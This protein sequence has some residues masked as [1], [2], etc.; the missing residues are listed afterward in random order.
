[1]EK[2]PAIPA[3]GRS[4][5]VTFKGFRLCTM[6]V[7]DHDH[8]YWKGKPRRSQVKNTLFIYEAGIGYIN[9]DSG[10]INHHSLN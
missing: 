10:I 4:R 9:G 8:T 3:N 6:K 5:S 1:V 7:K 2:K